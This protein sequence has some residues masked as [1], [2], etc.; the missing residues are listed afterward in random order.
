MATKVIC[1]ICGKEMDDVDLR[2]NIRID[3]CLGY[4]SKFDG[5]DIHL[6]ICCDC[7]DKIIE[8]CKVDPRAKFIS[9]D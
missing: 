3:K 4:G 7:L 1:N 2:N 8:S 6:D 9:I 5:E